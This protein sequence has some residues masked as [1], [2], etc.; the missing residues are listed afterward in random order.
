MYSLF[1]QI[2]PECLGE[3]L[4]YELAGNKKKKKGPCLHRICFT[5]KK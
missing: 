2:F 1:Q 5:K 4:S 3:A